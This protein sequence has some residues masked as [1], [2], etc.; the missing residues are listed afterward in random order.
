MSEPRQGAGGFR[1]DAHER[2]PVRPASAAEVASPAAAPPEASATESAAAAD[3]RDIL[4]IEVE[5]KNDTFDVEEK[6]VD[7]V[8]IRVRMP[9]RLK[10]GVGIVV[11]SFIMSASVA[12][13]LPWAMA[14]GNKALQWWA[15][16]VYAGSWI[17]MG[18]GIAVGGRAAKEIVT[19]WTVRAMGKRFGSRPRAQ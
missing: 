9:P 10:V 16:I 11:F 19:G 1:E 2:E 5:L 18:A 8:D 7:E 17:V 14:T 4:E 15:A 12:V 6:A 13:I 3:D